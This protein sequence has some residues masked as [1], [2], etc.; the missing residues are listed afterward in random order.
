MIAGQLQRN[1]S[2]VSQTQVNNLLIKFITEGLMP[3]SLDEQPAFK[4]FV[5]GLQPNCTVMRRATM[6]KRISQKA[7]LVKKNIKTAM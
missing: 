3:F 2:L 7:S 4:E 1:E 6:V 5:T